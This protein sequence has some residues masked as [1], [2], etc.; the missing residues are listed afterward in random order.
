[1][2]LD[3][4]FKAL[5]MNY[6]IIKKLNLICQ[7][8]MIKE[9]WLRTEINSTGNN[10]RIKNKFLVIIIFTRNNFFVVAISDEYNI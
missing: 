10:D 9:I 6:Y 4:F 7:K 1:M 8:I 3:R 2:L 5:S